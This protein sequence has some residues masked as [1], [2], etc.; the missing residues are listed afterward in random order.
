MRRKIVLA[1]LALLVV[2]FFAAPSIGERQLNKVRW[3]EH[4]P[5]A[6]AKALHATLRVADLHADSLMSPRD[7]STRSTVG[8]VDLPRLREGKVVIQGLGIVTKV[9]RGM[10]MDHNDDKSDVIRYL[11]IGNH[12]PLRTWNSI[13]ERALYQT[14]RA[15]ALEAKEAGRFVVLRTRADVQKLLT[16]N[17]ADG[18]VVGGVLGI[19]GAHALD[20]KLENLDLLFD[21][22]LRTVGL[23]H[24]FDNE[25][26]GSAHGMVQ[27]GLTQAGRALVA[28]IEAK[29]ITIDLAHASKQT[30][31]DVLAIAKR[32]VIVSHT[33]VLGTC[34]G[35]RNLSDDQLRAVAKNGGLV[36]IGFWSIAVCGH[37]PASIARAIMHTVSVIG[38][39]HVALGSDFDG[40]VTTPFDASGLVYVTDALLAAGVHEDTIRK[41]MGE[42]VLAFWS[43]QLP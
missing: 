41:V 4:T 13:I 28:K 12:W 2:A 16:A 26:A 7:L 27:G 30:F 17:A 29:G 8:H 9:P 6:R 32:P 3:P 42:N 33:G 14:D 43:K 24:F 34:K 35:P 36:G 25:W 1:T 40:A 11:A 18:R 39:D 10:R 19:E 37:D 38:V 15:A 21:R 20:G 31:L 5:S 22:G 23:A